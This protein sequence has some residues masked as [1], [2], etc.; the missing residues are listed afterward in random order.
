MNK[1]INIDVDCQFLKDI[2]NNQ[3]MAIYNLITSKGALRLW[4]KGIKPNRNWKI[5]QVKKYFG[6]NGSKE[7]LK[8][9]L[10]LLYD[11]VTGE[12]GIIKNKS[13]RK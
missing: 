3:Q 11:V 5:S 7:V 8:D 4:C 9:K 2:E 10:H 6:M 1:P 12:L 13:E